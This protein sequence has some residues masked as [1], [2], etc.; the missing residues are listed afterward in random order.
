M[1]L[2]SALTIVK[3]GCVV[4]CTKDQKFIDAE[5]TLIPTSHKRKIDQHAVYISLGNTSCIEIKT[6]EQTLTPEIMLSV[7]TSILKTAYEDI[8]TVAS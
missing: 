1:E 6:S 8:W 3:T 4:K 7:V 5:V 2:A